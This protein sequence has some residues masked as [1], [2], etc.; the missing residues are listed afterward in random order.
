MSKD[1]TN[2]AQVHGSGPFALFEEEGQLRCGKLLAEAPASVQI[3]QASGRRS[4]VKQNHMFMRFSQPGPQDLL[5]QAKAMA[6]ELD[7][8]FIWETCNQEIAGDLDFMTL[9]SEYFGSGPNAVQA[10]A[11]LICLQEAP[12]WFLRRGRGLFRPQPREQ[13][14]RALQALE[15]RRQQDEMV[16]AWAGSLAQDQWPHDWLDPQGPVGLVRPIA[17][18][19]KPDKQSLA[20]RAIDAACKARQLSPARLLL[21]CGQFATPLQLH[22]E[23]F[24]QEHFPKGLDAAFPQVE[25]ERA[26]ASLLLHI[27]TLDQAAVE[28]FSIDDSSTTEIDDALSLSISYAADGQTINELSLGVHIAVPALLLTPESRWDAMARERMSTVYAPGQKIQMLPEAIVRCFSLDEGKLCPALSLYVRFNGQCEVVGEET[29]LERVKIRANLRHD[30]LESSID[31]QVIEDW[32]RAV[33]PKAVLAEDLMQ[34]L[35]QLWRISKRLQAERETVRG[36]PEPRFRS[37]FHFR[38]QDDRVEIEQRRRDAPLDRIVAEM[39]ILAN[40]RWGRWVALNRLPA[41]FRSQSMGRARMTTHPI[42]HQGLGVGQYLWATS[43]LRRYADLVNQR[44]LLALATRQRPPFSQE[45]ADLHRVIAG[46]DARYDAYNDYQNTME[47]YWSM[48]WV[49]QM[50]PE[51]AERPLRFRAIALREQRARLRD[52]PLV[53]ALP[54]MPD[55]HAGRGLWVE[56]V[57]MDWLDLSIEVRM[58]AW[59]DEPSAE[60]A[61]GSS[62]TSGDGPSTS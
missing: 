42:A 7:V 33:W 23:L 11:M 46:F 57:K 8:A 18:L 37:D 4:K 49:E 54:D 6:A 55:G 40:S 53:F 13:I 16:Q 24:A 56:F 47:R 29:K 62:Q 5:V 32:E 38:I 41:I 25:L 58:L 36:R 30:Q 20:Y 60:S 34:A 61:N 44:Q 35:G 59:D 9:A 2:A 15:R 1:Q 28:A 43:P 17:L 12:I 39:M 31:E 14:D 10:C 50:Q 3:E 45:S 21:A 51:G 27:N 22:Q 52:A 26:I 19:L 48:R